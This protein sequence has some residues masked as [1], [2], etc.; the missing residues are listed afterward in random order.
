MNPV[1]PVLGRALGIGLVAGFAAGSLTKSRASFILVTVAAVALRALAWYLGI[2]VAVGAGI[3][4]VVGLFTFANE[5]RNNEIVAMPIG[6]VFG[7]AIAY[8]ISLS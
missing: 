5:E 8:L 3:G 7:I 2:G 6:A 1:I 4:A